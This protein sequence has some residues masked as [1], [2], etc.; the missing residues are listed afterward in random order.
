[1]VRPILPHMRS[2]CSSKL[3]ATP[4]EKGQ[5]RV[6]DADGRL[7]T[8]LDT[9]AGGSYG[10]ALSPDGRMVASCGQDGTVQLW[11][12]PSG[13][14]HATL[15]GHAGAVRGVAFGATGQRVASG[16]LDGTVNL[17]DTAS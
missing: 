17:W 5:S 6:W 10:V 2:T 8:T 13:R 4:P 9:R 12:I 14:P 3:P 7:L 16:G 15:Q 1:M 11:D